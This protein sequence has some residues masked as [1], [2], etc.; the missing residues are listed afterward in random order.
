[1]NWSILVTK[2]YRAALCAA[3]C[4][5]AAALVAPAAASAS[6]VQVGSAKWFWGNPLPQGNTLHDIAF[7]PGTTTGYA[8]GD[9]GT[10][11]KTTDAGSTWAGLPAGTFTSLKRVQIASDGS[12]IAGAGCVLR[13]ST[14][15]GVTFDR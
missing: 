4:L 5:I 9:F 2:G 10:I 3:V 11:L 14:N 7:M 12:I 1:M 13:I 8:V 6:N 15:A